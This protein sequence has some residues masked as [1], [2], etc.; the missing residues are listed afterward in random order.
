MLPPKF[1]CITDGCD[2]NGYTD[3]MGMCHRCFIEAYKI[4]ISTSKSSAPP[5]KMEAETSIEQSNQVKCV[6]DDCKGL[7]YPA[8]SGLCFKCYMLLCLEPYPPQESKESKEKAETKRAVEPLSQVQCVTEGCKGFGCSNYFGLC[9]TCYFQE[10]LLT[11]YDIQEG[12]KHKEIPDSKAPVEIVKT[13]TQQQSIGSS[14]GRV[15][16]EQETYLLT[17]PLSSENEK[18]LE[19]GRQ[20]ALLQGDMHPLKSVEAG[21][22]E[23]GQIHRFLEKTDS[24]AVEDNFDDWLDKKY[25]PKVLGDGTFSPEPPISGILPLRDKSVLQGGEEVETKARNDCTKNEESFRG[26][27]K[28]L[29]IGKNDRESSSPKDWSSRKGKAEASKED[30]DDDLPPLTTVEMSQHSILSENCGELS[31]DDPVPV[32]A[33]LLC[34]P[35]SMESK[36]PWTLPSSAPDLVASG[37]EGSDAEELSKCLSASCGHV[38]MDAVAGGYCVTCWVAHSQGQTEGVSNQL[39]KMPTPGEVSKICRYLE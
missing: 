5:V 33:V 8:Y 30:L 34:S 15:V 14:S 7:G 35:E 28:Q 24:R 2:D 25:P 1:K 38:A 18:F 17:P 31:S 9:R 26:G 3:T 13:K 36:G 27:D 4:A 20:K 39:V 19:S 10:L 11:M 21:E 32:D 16:D 22:V 23:H 37:D 12:S 6:A 29:V